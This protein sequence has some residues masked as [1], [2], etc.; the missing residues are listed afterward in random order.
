[1]LKC[2]H[3]WRRVYLMPRV[4]F[5]FQNEKIFHGFLDWY[6]HKIHSNVGSRRARTKASLSE[7]A[8]ETV[9]L[10]YANQYL[11]KPIPNPWIEWD[12]KG[13]K[14]NHS[15]Y[16]HI[17]VYTWR[18]TRGQPGQVHLFLKIVFIFLDN[19]SERH[20]LWWWRCRVMPLLLLLTKDTAH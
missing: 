4:F 12:E 5:F 20:K 14:K 9:P 19:V 16:V 8:T 17:C 2:V 7:Q 1:M 13:V 6:W 11:S 10:D 18:K 3:W 15:I